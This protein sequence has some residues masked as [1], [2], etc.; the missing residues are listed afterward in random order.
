MYSVGHKT[1]YFS[2]QSFVGLQ[3]FFFISCPFG[4]TTIKVA[5]EG[6]EWPEANNMSQIHLYIDVQ[7][8]LLR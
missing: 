6:L 1:S 5:N 8:F 7:D 2:P 3:Q 4:F